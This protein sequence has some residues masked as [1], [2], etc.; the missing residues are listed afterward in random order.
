MEEKEIR[1]KFTAHKCENQMEFDRI[2]SEIKA[3]QTK[4]NHPYLDRDRELAKQRELLEQQKEA[5]NIQLKAIKVERLDLEQK[6]KE[7]N[8]IYH[9]LKHELIMMNPREQFAHQEIGGGISE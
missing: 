4:F 9:E 8:R 3:E 6:R 5:I 2:M 1:A 7:A